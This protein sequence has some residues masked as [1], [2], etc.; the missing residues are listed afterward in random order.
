MSTITIN[1]T[2]SVSTGAS[3]G[4]FILPGDFTSIFYPGYVFDLTTQSNQSLTYTVVLST[5]VGGSTQVDV[6]TPLEGSVITFTTT[7][8]TMP[9]IS[10]TY[11]AVPTTTNSAHGSGATVDVLSL[12]HI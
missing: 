9:Y 12:I 11:I 2:S 8:G 7:P 10:G 5:L 4:Y 1:V 6:D 3:S